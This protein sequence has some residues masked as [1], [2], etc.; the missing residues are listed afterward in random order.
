MIGRASSRNCKLKPQWDFTTHPS[1]WFKIKRLT[2]V[3]VGTDVEQLELSYM[4]GGGNMKW[5]IDF[6]ERNCSFLKKLIICQLWFSNYTTS[7]CCK[8]NENRCLSRE[9]NGYLSHGRVVQRSTTQQYQR[10]NCCYTW[11]HKFQ[12]LYVDWR[13]SYTHRVHT[14]WFTWRSRVDKILEQI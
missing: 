8:G 4:V 14:V 13:K 1:R 5:Y 12:K 2:A 9:E 3:N 7:S 6:G 10:M 11:S